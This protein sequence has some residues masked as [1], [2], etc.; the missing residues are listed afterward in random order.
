MD[1]IAAFAHRRHFG[2]VA[3]RNPPPTKRWVSRVLDPSYNCFSFML[4]RMRLREDTFFGKI[5][6]ATNR[7]DQDRFLEKGILI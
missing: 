3:K 6:L 5:E 4:A 2:S 1:T 7:A